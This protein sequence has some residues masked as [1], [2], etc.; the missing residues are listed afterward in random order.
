[1][2][3]GFADLNIITPCCNKPSALNKLYYNFPVGFCRTSLRIKL[4]IY[5]RSYN[6]MDI[7]ARLQEITGISWLVIH[8]HI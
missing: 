4:D 2:K 6:E 8:Q 5:S 1:M 3:Y 7:Q